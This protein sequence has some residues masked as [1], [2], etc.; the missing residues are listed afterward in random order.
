M[1][2]APIPISSII[3]IINILYQSPHTPYLPLTS[4]HNPHHHHP[5]QLTLPHTLTTPS[6][7]SSQITHPRD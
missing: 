3:I 5:R 2:R 6:K 1:S 4:P 7:P